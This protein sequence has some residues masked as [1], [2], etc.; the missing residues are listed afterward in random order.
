MPVSLPSYQFCWDTLGLRGLGDGE[1]IE[2]NGSIAGSLGGTKVAV[3][4]S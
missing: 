3:S 1:S 4:L 2:G